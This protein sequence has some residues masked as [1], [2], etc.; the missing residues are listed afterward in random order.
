MIQRT[1]SMSFIDESGKKYTL[2]IRDVKEE[3]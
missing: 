1:A 3:V 2:S